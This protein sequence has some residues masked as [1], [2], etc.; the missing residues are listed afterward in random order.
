MHIKTNIL[1]KIH[2]ILSKEHDL[3]SF[4]FY[5]FMHNSKTLYIITGLH[6]CERRIFFLSNKHAH[7]TPPYSPDG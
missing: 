5:L 4:Y 1:Y 7:C 2:I 3:Y 6:G